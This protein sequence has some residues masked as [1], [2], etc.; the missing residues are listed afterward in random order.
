MYY[1]YDIE[2]E[3]LGRQIEEFVLHQRNLQS[4]LEQTDPSSLI[5]EEPE[6]L[7]TSF[8][9]QRFPT[10]EGFYLEGDIAR[11]TNTITNNLAT[12]DWANSLN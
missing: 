9:K 1:L 6:I 8:L 10:Q 5:Q 3:I 2:I 7:A 11:L 12:M 4:Y